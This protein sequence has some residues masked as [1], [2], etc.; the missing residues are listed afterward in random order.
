MNFAKRIKRTSYLTLSLRSSSFIPHRL[1]TFKEIRFRKVYFQ[2]QQR[3]H[4]PF[5]IAK[6]FTSLFSSSLAILLLCN[7]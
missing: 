5:G 1:K 7:V 3:Q 4:S 6:F 2:V